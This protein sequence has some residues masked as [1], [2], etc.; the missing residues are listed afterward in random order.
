MHPSVSVDL[1]KTALHLCFC[2]HWSQWLVASQTGGSEGKSTS[3]S[4]REKSNFP[5]FVNSNTRYTRKKRKRG[6]CLR[7]GAE[8]P[9]Y[10]SDEE[11]S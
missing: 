5:L 3:E 11:L 2:L 1:F 8:E 6:G 9:C 10:H 7:P 4:R